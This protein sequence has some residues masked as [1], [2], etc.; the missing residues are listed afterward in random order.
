MMKTAAVLCLVALLPQV[1]QVNSMCIPLDEVAQDPESYS[2]ISVDSGETCCSIVCGDDC[3]SITSVDCPTTTPQ[4]G[5]MC[6]LESPTTCSYD[7]YC[8]P[9]GR[10]ASTCV[11]TSF[12]NCES[13]EW[14]V[15][16]AGMMP[17]EDTA[18]P[19]P[20]PTLTE[21]SSQSP[22][23]TVEPTIVETANKS[24]VITT[25]SPTPVPIACCDEE[26][27]YAIPDSAPMQRA[28]ARKGVLLMSAC[29]FLVART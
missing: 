21:T 9:D 20:V 3:M 8:C 19:T 12:A 2:C 16:S 24:G 5:D 28:N 29:F 25:A 18:C 11:L 23:P 7:L 14:M 6:D 13:S 1:S 17:C 27:E 22:H 15:M 4:P 10:N 26:G